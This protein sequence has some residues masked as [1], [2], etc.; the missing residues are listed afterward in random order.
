MGYSPTATPRVAWRRA[1][2]AFLLTLLAIVVFGASFAVGYARM[3]D[4]RVLPGVAV[5]GVSLAGLNRAAAAATLRQTLPS[6]SAGRLVIDVD[7]VARSIP[8]QQFERDYD[9][10]LMLDQAFSI[11]RGSNFIEQLQEQLRVLLN[12]VSVSPAV[13]WDNEQ[14]AGQVAAIANGAQSDPV[15]AMLSHEQGRYVVS[16]SLEGRSVDVQS[17]VAVAM[18]AVNNTSPEAARITIETTA[19]PPAVTTAEAQAAADLA[20][21]VMGSELRIAGAELSTTIS[22]DALRGWVRLEE[23][24]A[25]G[26][27][28]LVIERDPV[29]QFVSNYGLETDVAPDNASFT[30]I[31]GDVGVVPST[32][33]RAADVESTT[34]NIMA[35]LETRANGGAAS[36]T[37]LALVPITPAFTTADAQALAPRVSKLSEWTTH[38]IPSPG[39]GDGA[40]IAIPTSIIDGYVIEPG[41]TLDFLD[42]IGPITSPPYETGGALIHGQIVAD[43]AIGGGMCSTSTTLFNAA[44]RYGL[45]ITARRNHSIYISRY[46]IGLDATVWISSPRSRQTMAIVNDTALPILIKG[47]NGRGTVTF[48]VWGVDDGRT[49][50]FSDPDVQNVVPGE[51]LY[52]YTDSRPPGVRELINDPYDAMDVAVTRTVRDAQGNIIHE[53]TFRSHYRKLDGITLVGRYPADPPAGTLIPA[54]QYHPPSQPTPTPTPTP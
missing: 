54:D 41:A 34:N 22:S 8:Y 7:G 21:R 9:L 25:G 5:S 49:V 42:V 18:A 52:E 53:D 10:G 30:F 46:P 45:G 32:D 17:V 20:E 12:G 15:R 40:N 29:A 13:T 11:G 14:L 38:F 35:A 16:P 50:S 4:G 27:W 51:R 3:H 48:E 24:A 28:Q 36:D 39:N 31:G 37:T 1:G 23:S 19:V 44:L 2:F 43:G 47:I 6:L 33:G 26:N